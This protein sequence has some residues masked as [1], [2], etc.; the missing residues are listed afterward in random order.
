MPNAIGQ[1]ELAIMRNPE[2]AIENGKEALKRDIDCVPAMLLLANAYMKREE[3]PA[4]IDS[5]N[6][7]YDKFPAFFRA[8]PSRPPFAHL[9]SETVC[10]Y[11]S[12]NRFCSPRLGCVRTKAAF[13][14]CLV[15]SCSPNI[16]HMRAGREA[17]SSIPSHGRVWHGGDG[18]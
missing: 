13:L 10:L 4:A 18:L 15:Y 14:S 2:A 9:L 3:W 11:A 1:L 16:E 17:R 12:H 8:M 5:L 6:K 7:F